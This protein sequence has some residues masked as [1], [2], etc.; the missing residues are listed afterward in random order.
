[1]GRRGPAPR[2]R[3]SGTEYSTR[4]QSGRAAVQHL[5]YKR[6]DPE[7]GL[8]SIDTDRIAEIVQDYIDP[9][10]RITTGI[11][12]SKDGTVTETHGRP[13]LSYVGLRRALGISRDTY[14]RWLDGYVSTADMSDD[15]IAPNIALRE[16][17]RAGDDAITQYIV[18]HG[19]YRKTSLWIRILET[20]GEIAPSKQVIDATLSGKLEMGKYSRFA[21]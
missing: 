4:T 6:L 20:R 15:S 13:Q 2:R 17:M 18:E 1:M 12:R 8:Y 5:R 10:R 16:A 19:D 21:R 11:K 14:L 9:D 3:Q 7:T